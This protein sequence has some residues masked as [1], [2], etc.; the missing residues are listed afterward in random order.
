MILTTILNWFVQSHHDKLH[1]IVLSKETAIEKQTI[2]EKGT[3]VNINITIIGEIVDKSVK[4]SGGSKVGWVNTGE[5]SHVHNIETNI[6]KF[7]E[8]APNIADMF[9]SIKSAIQDSKEIPSEEERKELLEALD[10]LTEDAALPED[11]RGKLLKSSIKGFAQACQAVSDIASV[12]S[13]VEGPIKNFFG[14][15]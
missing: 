7:K 12:W 1:E 8:S 13:T 10:G 14:I 9:S 2:E 3:V 4:I 5:I 15:Q 11:K 6:G